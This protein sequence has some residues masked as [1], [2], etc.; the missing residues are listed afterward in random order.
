VKVGLIQVDGKW[1]NL[2]LLKLSA[3]HKRRGDEVTWIDLTDFTFDCAY[4]SKIFMGGSGYDIHARLPDEIEHICPDY[5][6][7]KMDY[8]VGFTSRGCIR[9]CEFCIVR[10]K[11]GRM[12]E[13]AD[14]DEFLRH[15]KLILLDNNFLAT[16][17]WKNKLKYL[18]AKKIKVSFCQGLDIRLINDENAKLLSKVKW[19]NPKFKE[20]RLYFAFDD[21]KLE[22]FVRRGVAILKR[23]GIAPKYLMFFMLTNFNTTKEE[24]WHRFRVLEELGTDPYVMIYNRD[25][26]SRFHKDF[27]R[28]INQRRYKKVPFEKYNRSL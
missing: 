21:P 24:D 13:W 22:K 4:G 26:A 3:W 20:R 14:F 23:N 25:K 28:W 2:A 7:F 9:N 6:E 10:E 19:Y 15:D 16:P 12:K 1:P 27:A 11:E 8:S 18:I 17:N 5:E